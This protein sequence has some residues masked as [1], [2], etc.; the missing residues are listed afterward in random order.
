MRREAPKRFLAFAGDQY[1]PDGGWRDFRGSSDN[2]E[3]AVKL[4]KGR[5]W[6]H[7]VDGFTGEVWDI[8]ELTGMLQGSSIQ[9]VET[10]DITIENED[11]LAQARIDVQRLL[12]RGRYKSRQDWA[13][14]VMEEAIDD[15]VDLY[16]QKDGTLL[17]LDG[18]HRYLAATILGVPLPSKIHG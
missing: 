1:Y 5:D 8:S 4:I 10:K 17:L 2:F 14:A 15:P 11:V 13:K 9:L 6:G 16:R 18:N 12:D 7:V 3:E